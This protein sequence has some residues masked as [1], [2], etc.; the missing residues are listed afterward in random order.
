MF[1]REVISRKVRGPTT[2][3]LKRATSFSVDLRRMLCAF[4]CDL[5]VLDAIF[6]LTFNDA[7]FLQYHVCT[8][9]VVGAS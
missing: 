6:G 1:A 3:E 7:I 8:L 2:S 5:S 9:N 4:V